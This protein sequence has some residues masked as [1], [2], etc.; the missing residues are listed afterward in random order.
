MNKNTSKT[1][2]EAV[3][4]AGGAIEVGEAFGI[5]RQAIYQW[6]YRDSVPKH[7]APKLS[8]LSGV[9]VEQLRPDI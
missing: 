1:V 5:G 4:A 9:P 8:E 6:I 7:H 3:L 2:R